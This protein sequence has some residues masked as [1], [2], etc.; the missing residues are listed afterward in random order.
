MP[1][2]LAAQLTD[3]HGE[4]SIDA[5]GN[6]TLFDTEGNLQRYNVDGSASILHPDGSYLTLSTDQTWKFNSPDG[7]EL[8]WS[9]RDER[10]I[11]F[12]PKLDGSRWEHD[13]RTGFW[14]ER[15]TP[16]P[17]RPQG[18]WVAP[19]G[20][21]VVTE[22]NHNLFMV[23]EGHYYYR[24]NYE[25]SQGAPLL[26]HEWREIPRELWTQTLSLNRDLEAAHHTPDLEAGLQY[27]SSLNHLTAKLMEHYVDIG[28]MIA[29]EFGLVGRAMGWAWDA[30]IAADALDKATTDAEKL[31]IIIEVA[32]GHLLDLMPV[33]GTH[34]GHGGHPQTPDVPSAPHTPATPHPGAHNSGVMEPP[35]GPGPDVHP[36]QS[37]QVAEPRAA[38]PETPAPATPA[39]DRPPAAN[40]FEPPALTKPIEPVHTPHKHTDSTTPIH[41]GVTVKHLDPDPSP[42]H[43]EPIHVRQEPVPEGLHETG[44]PHRLSVVDE[45]NASAAL[46][47][48]LGEPPGPNHQA[49]HIV[50]VKEGGSRLD[51]LRDRMHEA[52]IG[53]DTAENGLYLPTSPE[54]ANPHGGIPHDTAHRN[55]RDDYAYTID[56]RLAHKEGEALRHELAV[57][58]E[59][60]QEGSFQLREAPAGWSNPPPETH[61]GAHGTPYQGPA[62]AP[63]DHAPTALPQHN[64]GA[65]PDPTHSAGPDAGVSTHTDQPGDVAHATPTTDQTHALTNRDVPADPH[66]GAGSPDHDELTHLGHVGDPH[67][68]QVA[69]VQPLHLGHAA[70]VVDPHGGVGLPD[71]ADPLH[72]GHAADVVD[73][74]GGVGLP[75]HADP[76]HLGHAADVVDP[77]G[78]VGLPDHADPLHLGHA[79]D[80]YD[81][82]PA[83]PPVHL[84]PP[85]PTPQQHQDL[86]QPMDPEGPLI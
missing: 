76:L 27:A 86:Q 22:V 79:T 63:P 31:Q 60:L 5:D 7:R 38:A 73:P 58:K 52:G 10:W 4:W 84:D 9:N 67:T 32:E 13:L 28:M 56:S 72:L 41:E 37:H 19:D 39:P 15:E 48:A 17:T 45:D 30:T 35:T 65:A 55:P 54:H 11:A 51:D 47:T 23:A 49:H 40:P 70:D 81:A 83:L 3:A 57:I 82:Q 24:L 25:A 42:S 50:P 66:S 8:T 18:E 85:H 53:R 14:I 64:A 69:Q 68:G 26:A 44:K 80:Q 12:E 21:T 43:G 75:D 46:R 33:P 29:P 77:H 16:H 34:G 59:E 61:G 71:H 6:V 20:R 1:S 78:G 62:T 74:H 2:P 36:T